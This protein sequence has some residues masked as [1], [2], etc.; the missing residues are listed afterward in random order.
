MS[1]STTRKAVQWTLN[2]P[3]QF[4]RKEKD[5]KLLL[6]L[7]LKEKNPSSFNL[8]LLQGQSRYWPIIFRIL[9]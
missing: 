1:K 3:P 2:R 8:S 5:I 4:E 6:L 7:A 9:P